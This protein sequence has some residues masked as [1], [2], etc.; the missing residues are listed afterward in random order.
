MLESGINTNNNTNTNTNTN[1][2]INTDNTDNRLFKRASW[3]IGIAYKIHIAQIRQK[4]P[5]FTR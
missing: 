4:Y 1:A 5:F 2:N 3:H